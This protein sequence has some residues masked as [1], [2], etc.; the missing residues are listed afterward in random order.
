MNNLFRHGALLTNK[1]YVS[2]YTKK[3]ENK[4][5]S[6]V[7]IDDEYP[8]HIYFPYDLVWRIGVDYFDPPPLHYITDTLDCNITLKDYQQECMDQLAPEPRGIFISPPGTGKTV[9]GLWLIA[10]LNL[11]T[12]VLVNSIYLLNQWRE[13]CEKFLN[14][15]PGLI[16]DG[17]YEV[18]DITIASF[19]SLRKDERLRAVRNEFSLVIVDECHRVPANTFKTVLSNLVAYWKLGITGTYNRKDKLEFIADWMLST[20]K[21]KN[22]Y[23]D[24]MRPS[25]LIVNTGIRLEECDGY[26]DCLNNLEDNMQLIEKIEYMVGKCGE[27]RHQL[28]IS[29]RLATVDILSASFPE[30]IIVTGQTDREERKN[31]NERVLENKII[32]STTLQEGVNIV[33]LDTIH[34]IHPNNNLP[35]LEQRICRINRPIDGKKTPFV[36][37]YWY[38]HGKEKGFNVESQQKERYNFYKQKGYKIYEL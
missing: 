10:Q 22:T 12:L 13:E 28:I 14:Y 29:F 36:V 3:V 23:D 27:D 21:V 5:Y 11:K 7:A 15:T 34:L 38:K 37:D 18:K 19:Q 33:P 35:M 32:I 6:G 24:T 25:V 31:L 26:V 16:G 4:V 8:D 20:R 1:K 17:E 30:A 2:Q 9:M